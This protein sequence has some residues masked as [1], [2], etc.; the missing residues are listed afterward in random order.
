MSLIDSRDYTL[1]VG[2]TLIERILWRIYR[3]F[4]SCYVCGSFLATGSCSAGAFLGIGRRSREGSL[5]LVMERVL[6]DSKAA[7]LP[8]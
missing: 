3:M 7:F 8:Y 1:T 5:R 2:N 6:A 4:S